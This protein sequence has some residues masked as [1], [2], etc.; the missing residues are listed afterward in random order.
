[1]SFGAAGKSACATAEHLNPGEIHVWRIELDTIAE[2]SL[3]PP[4]PDE[5]ERAARFAR[6]ELQHR[7]LQ[8]HRAL[9]AIL[10][11]VTGGVVRIAVAA[12]GKPWLPDAPEWKFNLSHSRGLALAAVARNVEVGVDVEYLRPQRDWEAIVE[13]FFPPSAAAEFFAAPEA[14]RERQF[15][16]LWTRLEARWKALGVGL[17]G[18]SQE[19]E[20][21]W[22]IADLDLG[23]DIAGAVAAPAEGMR[24]VM[25]NFGDKA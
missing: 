14:D 15:F 20:G 1:M 4:L 10:N 9:R 7:Y 17:H 8:S 16:R 24:V 18:A 21:A 6:P 11:S 3:P 23:R 5:T 22:T 13:R 12:N 2:V 19:I 25:R